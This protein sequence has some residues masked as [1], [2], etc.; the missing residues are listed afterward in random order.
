MIQ[1][2]RQP[3]RRAERFHRFFGETVLVHRRI[4]SLAHFREQAALQ[5]FQ[6]IDYRAVIRKKGA[7][8]KNRLTRPP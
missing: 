2:G 3:L 8:G 1:L 7:S 6:K 5:R 4:S